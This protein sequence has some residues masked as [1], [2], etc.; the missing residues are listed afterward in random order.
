[1]RTSICVCSRM[2]TDGRRSNSARLAARED[3][4]EQERLRKASEKK[5]LAKDARARV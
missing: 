1:M 5:R 2:S 4:E 3:D